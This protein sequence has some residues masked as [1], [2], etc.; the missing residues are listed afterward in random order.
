MLTARRPWQCRQ[1]PDDVVA[2][3]EQELH[4]SRLSARLLALRGVQGAQA[5]QAYLTYQRIKR[6]G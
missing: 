4:L 5:A 1:V 6:E 2:E 3:L